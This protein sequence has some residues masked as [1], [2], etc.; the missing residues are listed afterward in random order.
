MK[1]R[2][3]SHELEF[4][5]PFKIAH[6]TR[7]GT[8]VLIL[9]LEYSNQ[10]GYA[11]ASF[12]PYLNET[13]EACRKQIETVDLASCEASLYSHESISYAVK[14]LNLS[15]FARNLVVNA[16]T[17]LGAKLKKISLE[18]F[19]GI[20]NPTTQPKTCFTLTKND[21][22]HLVQK[23]KQAKEFTHL[24][25]KLD[26]EKDIEFAS[27]IRYLTQ[28]PFCADVN[29]G[30]EKVPMGQVLETM[31]VLR[32]LDCE[33]I[34]QPFS[35][36]N[37]RRHA[38]L[39]DKRIIPIYADES[40]QN[41]DD[42]IQHARNFDGINIKLLKSGGIDRALALA[43]TASEKKYGI[44]IGCMSESSCGCATAVTLQSYANYLDIDGPWLIKND[45]FEGF[46][47]QNGRFN[48]QFH[49]GIGVK[50]KQKL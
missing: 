21:L 38:E 23:L 5:H 31:D 34:E 18:D 2:L 26:G 49:E 14:T 17:D 35:K 37:Y 36:T 27:T 22:P 50:P 1:Y 30:W 24:K 10:T 43:R 9:S 39:R 19:C 33:L 46:S 6:G 48:K 13:P 32:Q 40:V 42:Y 12:P 16:L 4:T 44:I 8:Q 29:Q 15:P 47:I 28:K 45:L 3:D 11:E 20:T 25:L 41:V 7:T